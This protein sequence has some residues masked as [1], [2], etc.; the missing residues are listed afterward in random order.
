MAQGEREIGVSR[1]DHLDSLP[2]DA[3]LT[4]DHIDVG[5]EAGFLAS[6]YKRALKGRLSPPCGKP[7]EAKVH[8]SNLRDAL[9]DVRRATGLSGQA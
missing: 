9:A 7:Y 1:F 5:L 6:E 2:L 4:W 3:R 8:H